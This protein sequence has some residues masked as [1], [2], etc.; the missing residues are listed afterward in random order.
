MQD[1]IILCMKDVIT[2]MPPVTDVDSV[3]PLTE[4]ETDSL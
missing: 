2:K 4:T 1:R 3:A